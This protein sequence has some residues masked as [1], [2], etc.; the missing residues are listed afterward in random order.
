MGE[1]DDKSFAGGKTR[2][3]KKKRKKKHNKTHLKAVQFL[4]SV[5]LYELPAGIYLAMCF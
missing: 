3:K 5:P 4:P 2:T 1:S